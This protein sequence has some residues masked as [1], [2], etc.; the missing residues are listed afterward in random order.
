VSVRI[1]VVAQLRD[2]IKKRGIG[3]S[4]SM[5]R[6]GQQSER[7]ANG[8]VI[9]GGSVIDDTVTFD[10]S[11]DV[12]MYSFVGGD[13]S[14]GFGTT[15]GVQCA[16]VGPATIGDYCQI[17]PH[18]LVFGEDHPL[19]RFSTYTGKHLLSRGLRPYM[20]NAPVRVGH[21][22]W[23][24]CNAMVLRG[25]EVGNG[26][27]IAAGTVVA[28]DV[29]P[30][31]VVAGNPGRVV[32]DRLDPELAA[33]VDETEWWTLRGD[34]QAVLRELARIDMN[35]SPEEARA[36]LRRVIETLKAGGP[37]LRT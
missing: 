14:I 3:L 13:V 15:I 6:V 20:N 34:D 37:S 1:P 5:W 21:G 25:A 29:P 24:G 32:R 10:G 17:G 36:E 30:Y 11:N 31:T 9:G 27:V 28:G 7:R 16:V 23:I 35:E 4:R 26:A 33:L 18:V 2:R 12:G 8:V 19:D 22:V